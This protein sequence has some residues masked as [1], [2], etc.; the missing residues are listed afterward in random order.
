MQQWSSVATEINQLAVAALVLP[1]FFL[2]KILAVPEGSSLKNYINKW[3]YFSWASLFSSIGLCLVYKSVAT[4]LMG[5]SLN[6]GTGLSC[7]LNP[8]L[9]FNGAGLTFV[10]GIGSLFIGYYVSISKGKNE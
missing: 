3:L 6:L 9:I 5:K 4:C 10:L 7:N 1:V 8:I 2:R